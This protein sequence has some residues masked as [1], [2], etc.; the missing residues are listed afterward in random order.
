MHIQSYVSPHIWYIR[1]FAS[2]VPNADKTAGPGDLATSRHRGTG[3]SSRCTMRLSSRHRRLLLLL[4]PVVCCLLGVLSVTVPYAVAV[5][6][7][8]IRPLLHA[9]CYAG[10]CPP[11]SH[12]FT[13]LLC[14]YGVSVTANRLLLDRTVPPAVESAGCRWTP[15]LRPLGLLSTLLLSVFL[16]GVGLFNTRDHPLVHGYFA[17]AVQVAGVVVCATFLARQPAGTPRLVSRLRWAICVI[18]AV[19]LVFLGLYWNRVPAE[20]NIAEGAMLSSCDASAIPDQL[21]GPHSHAWRVK[22]KFTVGECVSYFMLAMFNLT[23]VFDVYASLRDVSF[24]VRD[25]LYWQR[26]VGSSA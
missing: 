12:L 18:G 22:M 11:E 10:C 13:S 19:G 5:R 4:L 21:W 17:A 2:P 8:H 1:Q 24:N 15:L 16:C 26:L 14:L 20:L 3:W 25:G 9:L 23:Y 6:L 7:G